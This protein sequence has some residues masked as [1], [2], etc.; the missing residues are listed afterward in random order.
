[1][2]LHG[3]VA[4]LAAAELRGP[5]AAA[6]AAAALSALGVVAPDRLGQV[7]APRKPAA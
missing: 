6:E 2:K 7:I 3:G 4:A 1:M 5:D